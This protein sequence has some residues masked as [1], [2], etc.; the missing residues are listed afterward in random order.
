MWIVLQIIING[1]ALWLAAYLVPGIVYSGNVLYLL[2]AGLVMGLVNV[3]VKPLVTL[4]SLPLIILTLGLFYLVV[5]GLMLWL[6]AALL[7]GLSV[8][9]CLPAILGGLVI[10]VFNWVVRGL[11][12]DRD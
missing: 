12:F 10:G 5:N 1:L 2:V 8:Q 9:G 3:L 7:P 11:V 6:V 4:L